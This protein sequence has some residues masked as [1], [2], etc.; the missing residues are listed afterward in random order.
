MYDWQAS[1][2]VFEIASIGM[3][4]HNTATW[5]VLAN[6]FDV[7]LC[8]ADCSHSDGD[9]YHQV[10]LRNYGH[11]IHNVLQ[12]TREK[13]IKMRYIRWSGG[14]GTGPQSLIHL[15]LNVCSKWSFNG[16]CVMKWHPIKLKPHSEL[17]MCG[18]I[19]KYFQ[20]I[21][22]NEDEIFVSVQLR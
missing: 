14:N 18:V 3:D 8:F 17:N 5:H 9:S 13:I 15:F 21:L 4:A 22:L 20:K 10:H 1:Q 2:E 7:T 11:V 16:R 12:G 19:V 6:T